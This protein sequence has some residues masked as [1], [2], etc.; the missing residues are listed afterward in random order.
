MIML[1]AIGFLTFKGSNMIEKF[2]SGWSILLYILYGIFLI[3][4]LF[5]FGPRIQEN[6]SSGVILSKW[7]LGGFKYALYNLG[8]IPVILFCVSHI[9]TR[10]EAVSAGLIGGLIGIMP[11]FL[12]Y[13]AA[14]S[15]YPTVLSQEIPAVFILQKIGS[16]LLLISFQVILF[17]TLIET[18]TGLIHA[19]NQR[20]QSALRAKGK[21][22]PQWQR[23]LVAVVLLLIGLGISTFGFINLIA[24]GY[25]T[26]SWGFLFVFVIPVISVGVYK[27]ISRQNSGKLKNKKEI[28]CE[29]QKN[30]KTKFH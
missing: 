25:G 26:I 4:A 11:G 6:F 5:K 9:E 30:E 12:F 13:I 15:H 8:V 16:P 29:A 24:K 18:G 14:V 10:K 7:S 23:P 19:F 21:E 17:G 28:E 20:I 3:A 27:I 2:L 1:A 22:L